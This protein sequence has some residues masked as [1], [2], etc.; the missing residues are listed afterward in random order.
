MKEEK[1]PRNKFDIHMT[2]EEKNRIWDGVLR[3][4]TDYPDGNSPFVN[5]PSN[6]DGSLRRASDFPPGTAPAHLLSERTPEEK[7]EQE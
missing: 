7:K 5:Q 1:K 6:W 4:A 3:R 2:D